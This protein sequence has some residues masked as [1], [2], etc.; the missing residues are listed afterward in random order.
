MTIL[1]LLAAW[2][3]LTYVPFLLLSYITY[4]KTYYKLCLLWTA[5]G[6]ACYYFDEMEDRLFYQ[7]I[8]KPP[9]V[10]VLKWFKTRS[11]SHK[12]VG[13]WIVVMLYISDV[14]DDDD[15]YDDD[16]DA[17]ADDRGG[18][19]DEDDVGDDDYDDNCDEE[20]E[21]HHYHHHP[22]SSPPYHHC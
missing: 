6:K 2:G 13:R 9:H 10:V 8:Q 18:G 20:E 22:I 1:R 21:D 16:A 17:D 7:G 12:S 11:K 15:G 19:E 3:I 5:D 4:R 14:D